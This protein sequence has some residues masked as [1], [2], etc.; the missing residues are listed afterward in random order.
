MDFFQQNLVLVFFRCGH[1]K[2][3]ASQ[4][5]IS[6]KDGF[7]DAM[8]PILASC[9][10]SS[11]RQVQFDMFFDDYIYEDVRGHFLA[12]AYSITVAY[13]HYSESLIFSY[14]ICPNFCDLPQSSSLR[15]RTMSHSNSCGLEHLKDTQRFDNLQFLP[16]HNIVQRDKT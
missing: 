8:R 16:Y 5:F 4:E 15:S 10:P 1:C 6:S 11:I 2:R 14:V 13:N 7:Y 12:T 3:E 9:F